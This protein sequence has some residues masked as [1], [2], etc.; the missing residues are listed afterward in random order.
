[1][2]LTLKA[3][4]I[5]ISLQYIPSVYDATK[6]PCIC[7]STN[8]VFFSTTKIIQSYKGLGPQQSLIL[9]EQSLQM[10]NKNLASKTLSCLSCLCY[11]FSRLNSSNRSPA[12]AFFLRRGRQVKGRAVTDIKKPKL[13]KN[14]CS[15]QPLKLK[16]MPVNLIFNF[17]K[18]FCY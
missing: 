13:Y 8:Q 2:S 1:M 10:Q 16:S 12:C 17:T 14:I 4:R 5:Y 15:I 6:L 9:F 7:F 11:Y 18:F 3:F